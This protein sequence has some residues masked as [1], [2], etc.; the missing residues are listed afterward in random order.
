[1]K[2]SIGIHEVQSLRPAK[3]VIRSADSGRIGRQEFGERRD[4]DKNSKDG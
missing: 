1:M 3:Q 4:E 2:F